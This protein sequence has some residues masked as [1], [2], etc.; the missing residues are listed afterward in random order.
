MT[1]KDQQQLQ[2][3]PLF[4]LWQELQDQDDELI[5]SESCQIVTDNYSNTNRITSMSNLYASGIESSR[6]GTN[7]NS[8]KQRGGG[9]ERLDSYNNRED[10]MYR[11]FAG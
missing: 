2:N 9:L 10:N 4:L 5:F 8:Y 6:A 1:N 11:P 7:D 3:D